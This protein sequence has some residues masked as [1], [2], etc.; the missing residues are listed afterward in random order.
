MESYPKVTID[1]TK[2]PTVTWTATHNQSGANISLL[3]VRNKAYSDFMSL[4]LNYSILDGTLSQELTNIAYAS[5]VI[6]DYRCEIS[7]CTITGTFAEPQDFV[8][9]TLN[10]GKN[11][12]K[13][14][15]IEYFDSNSSLITYE[16]IDNIDSE[17]ILTNRSVTNCRQM[18]LTFQEMWEPL[19]ICCLQEW[20]VGAL[21]EYGQKNLI[22]LRLNETRDPITRELPISTLQ[23]NAYPI[24]GNFDIRDPN[25]AIKY[26][27]P[28]VVATLSTTI[29]MDDETFSINFG[30][31]YIK[32]VESG[33]NSTLKITFED[34]I[35]RLNDFKFSKSLLY[36]SLDIT[37]SGRWARPV[38]QSIVSEALVDCE[39]DNDAI[40]GMVFGYLPYTSCRDA[41]KQICFEN[42]FIVQ[43]NDK[44]RI[45]QYSDNKATIDII[46]SS[47]ITE[48]PKFE[49][50]DLTKTVTVPYVN[51]VSLESNTSD[52]ATDI[53]HSATYA[54]EPAADVSLV[55][56]S[57]D[58]VAILFENNLTNAHVI[59]LNSQGTFK[60]VG[61]K[62]V[63]TGGQ[64]QLTM[65]D[66]NASGTLKVNIT[67]STSVTSVN[68]YSIAH[69][70][71]GFLN[72]NILKTTFEYINTGQRAGSKVQIDL[73][74]KQMVGWITHQSI[75]LV[76]GMLTQIE[77][78]GEQNVLLANSDN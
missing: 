10:F 27:K 8:T 24:L 17:I 46:S 52:L 40:G 45:S 30:K 49:L 38:I 42:R 70:T 44:I 26:L 39:F 33:D 22:S 15:Y 71:I 50:L 61:R 31:W 63:S 20:T 56:V 54:H 36:G 19:Y 47:N 6:S 75:D 64:N 1:L 57:G 78:L 9:T 34:L 55:R 25:G 28:G 32:K 5:N 29:V 43:T 14:I 13:K 72:R 65:E 74:G 11:F 23:M 37:D 35:G 62:Y 67:A 2:N 58:G 7:G 60:L 3:S 48:P 41:L 68:A 16:T 12:P 59:F 66:Q 18:R 73:P 4:S 53:N 77:I 51:G 76:N 21:L 69:N